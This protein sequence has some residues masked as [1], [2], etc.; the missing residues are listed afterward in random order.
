MGEESTMPPPVSKKADMT[1]RHSAR[2]A[3]SSPTLKVIQL[4]I[5]TAETGS[6][7][8][9]IRLESAFPASAPSAG[10][11][12]AAPAPASTAR[13]VARIGLPV[14]AS[15]KTR[16]YPIRLEPPRSRRAGRHAPAGRAAR[17]P[18]RGSNRTA[19]RMPP[20]ATAIT[21]N[22][23]ENPQLAWIPAM[24]GRVEAITEKVTM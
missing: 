23:A 7:V 18:V 16:A 21:T 15:R 11:A 2:S 24:T 14:P 1:A 13:R 17:M 6:P 8:A 12:S 10:A 4:P 20:A 19:A 9:G 5:P 22:S 3:G